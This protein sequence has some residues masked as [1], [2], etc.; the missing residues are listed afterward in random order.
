[1]PKGTSSLQTQAEVGRKAR[2]RSQNGCGNQAKQNKVTTPVKA[3]PKPKGSKPQNSPISEESES[4]AKADHKRSPLRPATTP[5]VEFGL[6]T[7]VVCPACTGQALSLGGLGQRRLR[8][9]CDTCG[10]W[11]CSACL[12]EEA[13]EPYCSSVEGEVT[14]HVAVCC[15]AAARPWRD[16]VQK[17]LRKLAENLPSGATQETREARKEVVRRIDSSITLKFSD[18]D[19][20]VG[21]KASAGAEIKT[22][23]VVTP[24]DLSPRTKVVLIG[25]TDEPWARRGEG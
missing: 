5:V 10:V 15:H 6:T 22:V 17:F 18:N 11:Q 8:G 3:K 25:V 1:M 16:T 12:L 20:H 13:K 9:R 24:V 23:Q 2:T 4:S 14:H 21:A 7:G 19:V